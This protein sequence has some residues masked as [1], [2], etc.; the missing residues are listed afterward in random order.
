MPKH[1]Q[2]YRFWDAFLE[3]PNN[4]TGPKILFCI[5]FVMRESL[6][7]GV[8]GTITSIKFDLAIYK[9][10]AVKMRKICWL[11]SR[12]WF[13][14]NGYCY[15]R[16]ALVTLPFFIW[17]SIV[18]GSLCNV[19][20]PLQ[21][22]SSETDTSAPAARMYVYLYCLE[23]FLWFYASW[24]NRDCNFWNIAFQWGRGEGG[25]V[26]DHF[27]SPK[28]RFFVKYL[29]NFYQKTAKSPWQCLFNRLL[30]TKPN[31][32]AAF[33]QENRFCRQAKHW[34]RKSSFQRPGKLSSPLYTP[35]LVLHVKYPRLL[36][37][38]NRSP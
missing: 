21:G 28:K 19:L 24:R 11:W 33:L 20:F 22:V 1:W 27:P 26:H 31:D 12:K 3:S 25:R 34:R 10:A 35:Q 2:I 15:A 4:L 18:R 7:I 17:Y 6:C 38:L 14:A 32:H 29:S 30:N 37:R 8:E 5:V 36:N 16:I 13:N 23:V 9:N